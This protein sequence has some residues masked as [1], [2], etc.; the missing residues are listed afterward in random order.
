MDEL[1][2]DGNAVAGLLQ[3]VF[4]AEVTTAVGGCGS[5]GAREAMGAAHV[6]RGAGLV[7]RCAHCHNTLMTIVTDEARVWIGFHGMSTLEVAVP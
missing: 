5:C 7:L 3:E 1:M 2:L 6:F 4:S